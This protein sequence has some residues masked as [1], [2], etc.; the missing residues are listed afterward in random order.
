MVNGTHPREEKDASHHGGRLE[1]GS[2]S[3]S[4][5]GTTVEAPGQPDWPAQ[6]RT[7]VITISATSFG[8]EIMTTCEA[9]S[10]SVVCA[11]MRS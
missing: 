9:P 2:E 3:I 11:P 8:C 10:I 4:D 5:P 1:R 7:A 6:A